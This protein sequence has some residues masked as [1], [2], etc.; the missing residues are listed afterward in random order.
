MKKA[1]ITGANRSIGFESAK[2]LL[3]K[4][5]YVYLGCRDINKGQEAVAKLK[6]A[7]L[8]EVEAIEIDISNKASIEA[9]A[10]TL[11]AKTEVLDVLIN[12]AGILGSMPQQAVKADV[13]NIRDVFNT[14]FFGIIETIGAFMDLLQKAPL[15]IIVNVTSGLGSLTYHSDPAWPYYPFKTAAYGPSKTAL[16]AYTVALAFELRETPFKV[17]AIDPGYT[18]TDFNDHHGPGTV[19]SAGAIIVKYATLDANGPT[20]KFFSNDAL[21]GDDEYPW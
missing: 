14:N 12:N 18:A 10:K 4:G 5:Y 11:S 20:G 1:L 6:V 17:N 16:N 2:Q 15:P 19:E 9:A 8:T 21:H 7:G 3:E 13:A